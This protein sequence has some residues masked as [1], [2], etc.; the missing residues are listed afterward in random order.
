MN[1]PLNCA[2][3]EEQLV[4]FLQWNQYSTRQ[5]RPN[6]LFRWMKHC[7]WRWSY[8]T[9]WMPH[10]LS[11]EF[12]VRSIYCSVE[13]CRLWGWWILKH[14]FNLAHLWQ[15]LMLPNDAS[16]C[17]VRVVSSFILMS[18]HLFEH[19]LGWCWEIKVNCIQKVLQGALK[20]FWVCIGI[21]M[22]FCNWVLFCK[23]SH[24]L[25]VISWA[26]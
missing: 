15:C 5:T 19:V 11:S 13:G 16:I 24:H 20:W 1:N 25:S 26:S 10:M 9:Y 6:C 18:W 12:S 7:Q 2:I 17:W 22:A 23:L 14:W 4:G 21:N 8:C 3:V